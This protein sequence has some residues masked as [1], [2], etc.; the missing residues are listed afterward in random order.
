M[1]RGAPI[2]LAKAVSVSLIL[3][4]FYAINGRSEDSVKLKEAA[5]HYSKGGEFMQA[6]NDSTDPAS[7]YARA[8]EEYKLSL[9]L[10]PEYSYAQ[11][12]MGQALKGAVR[13]S[14]ALP[15][16]EKAFAMFGAI[17]SGELK[18]SLQ[19]QALNNIK[20]CYEQLGKNE[21]AHKTLARELELQ[22]PVNR[23]HVYSEISQG[24]LKDKN[25]PLAKA[26]LLSALK[27][28]EE[29]K[30]ENGAGVWQRIILRHWDN[31]CRYVFPVKEC[32]EGVTFSEIAMPSRE[33]DYSKMGRIKAIE[34]AYE[35]IKGNNYEP[36]MDTYQISWNVQELIS[37]YVKEN[38]YKRGF[39]VYKKA[40]A[41]Y[42]FIRNYSFS[43][44]RPG[45]W[46]IYQHYNRWDALL[47]D[48]ESFYDTRDSGMEGEF[49]ASMWVDASTP[50]L[51]AYVDRLKRDGG[52]ID[53]KSVV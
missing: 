28:L 9:Y 18:L 7:L 48:M 25:L 21:E 29:H 14:E 43:G 17:N 13:C 52:K 42:P 44:P 38:D 27:V 34:A 47:K 26:N 10:N 6:A 30:T 4:L 32:S 1:N 53:R 45:L 12:S 16:Y 46:K 49:G 50:Y 39:E 19:S 20:L 36:H 37:L 51:K 3:L 41:V 31:A 8:I 2:S 40:E 23:A 33:T 35:K 15:Y 22:A 11:Y 24:Y 5:A